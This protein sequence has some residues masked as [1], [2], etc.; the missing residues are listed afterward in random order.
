MVDRT[1][2]SEPLK[3]IAIEYRRIGGGSVAGRRERTR[4]EGRWQRETIRQP[5]TSVAEGTLESVEDGDGGTG[6]GRNKS[7]NY[8]KNTRPTS[9]LPLKI[10]YREEK[11]MEEPG[12][13]GRW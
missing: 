5:G 3:R 2:S 6:K 7:E 9:P 4:F 1:H 10:E 13:D 11:L 8:N 12:D